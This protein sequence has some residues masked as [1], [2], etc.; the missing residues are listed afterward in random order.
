MRL[1]ERPD[2]AGGIVRIAVHQRAYAKSYLMLRVQIGQ[3]GEMMKES[4][5]FHI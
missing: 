2:N 3:D 4:P 1:F 5:S